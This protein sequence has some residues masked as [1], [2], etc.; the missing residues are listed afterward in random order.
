MK[1]V[2]EVV[3]VTFSVGGIRRRVLDNYGG[4]LSYATPSRRIRLGKD[5]PS[6]E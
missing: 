3:R 6:V 2:A 5:R 4:R 1:P